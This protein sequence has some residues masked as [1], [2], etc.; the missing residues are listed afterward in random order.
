MKKECKWTCLALLA[1]FYALVL[2]E[3][4][5]NPSPSHVSPY[6]RLRGVDIYDLMTPCCISKATW[7]MCYILSY[8]LPMERDCVRLERV[9]ALGL[10]GHP[11]EPQKTSWSSWFLG[12]SFGGR[13]HLLS[14]WS[15]TSHWVLQSLCYL[16]W[17]IPGVNWWNLKLM[18][19]EYSPAFVVNSAWLEFQVRS[20]RG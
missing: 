7:V 19:P 12:R 14:V 9:P 6:Y 1:F 2:S 10:D 16:I 20:L 4:F 18:T 3:V 5:M 11:T 13:S 17:K 15:K 8:V